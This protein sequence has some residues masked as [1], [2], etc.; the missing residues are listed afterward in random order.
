MRRF[1]IWGV[2]LGCLGG[3]V[4]L[5]LFAPEFLQNWWDETFQGE[6]VRWLP[7]L[8]VLLFVVAA[9]WGWH[10][11]QGKM[12]LLVLLLIGAHGLLYH[13]LPHGP[14]PAPLRE[15]F[16]VFLPWAFP[17]L[18]SWPERTLKSLWGWA[19]LGA[20]LSIWLGSFI[21]AWNQG[22]AAFWPTNFAAIPGG[23]KSIST[24]LAL[25]ALWVLPFTERPDL[26]SSWTWSLI[27]LGIASLHGEP[28]WT[29]SVSGAPWPVFFSFS[30]LFL[31]SGLYGLTWRR[32][33]LDELMGIPG[34]RAF[35]ES[36]SR[37]GRHYA[38]AM[39][40]VDHFKHFND[41]YG[42]QVGDQIL[43]FIAARLKKAS[44]GQ[45]F[46]YGGEEFALIMPG[47]KVQGMVPLLEELRQSIESSAFTIRG[48]DRP[49]HKPRRK[50]RP[51]GG[52]RK[53]GVTVSIGVARKSLLH[54]TP[55]AVLRAADEALYRAKQMG[56]NRVESERSSRE[57]YVKRI[58]CHEVKQGEWHEDKG[59]EKADVVAL[60]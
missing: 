7:H 34:R 56:R 41:H 57:S 28:W 30:A 27:S 26:R 23:V 6:M 22:F 31:L 24:L 16:A 32:A 29:E 39:V 53:V 2:S 55:E 37:L 3:G 5:L 49:S 33:Y 59:G 9:L 20:A 43:R 60:C 44:F 54:P 51:P 14:P 47:R 46:R 1:L 48:K 15:G 8:P 58:N 36:L 18:L 13:P 17:L 38:I 10:L 52:R 40:D 42:H 35:E 45:A 11:R 21:W 19:R 4:L 12:P 50:D 25:F